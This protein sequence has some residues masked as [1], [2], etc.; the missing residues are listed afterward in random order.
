MT[1]VRDVFLNS[2]YGQIQNGEDY[3]IVT[4]DLGAPSLDDLRIYYPDR[5]ISVG[6]A[7]Q[8]LIAISAGLTMAG[9]KVIAYGLNPFPV[10]RAFDQLK[11]VIAG[12]DIPLTICGLNAG[13]CSAE[14]GYTHIPTEDFGMLRM[15]PNIEVYNPT[16]CTIAG[17]LADSTASIKHPRYIRFDKKLGEKIY[18]QAEIELGKGFAVYGCEEAEITVV[19]LGNYVADM[20]KLADEFGNR[21]RVID[22]FKMKPDIP[23]LVDVLGNSKTIVTLEENMLEGGLGSFILEVLSD[24]KLSIPTHR[25]GV[26]FMPY[27]VFANRDYIQKD[28]K[29]DFQS[30]RQFLLNLIE[31]GAF[32]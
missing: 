31:A 24:S 8:S 5:F 6:I 14:A 26:R 19:T 13:L 22:V 17:L 28:Q 10:T 20:R 9:H 7:E 3:Y 25:L 4:P 16:D 27:R 11:S 1:S 32:K 23:A 2:I 30:V 21:I 29:I 18:E 12:M 15:L